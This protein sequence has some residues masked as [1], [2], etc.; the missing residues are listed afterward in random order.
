MMIFHAGVESLCDASYKCGRYK[1]PPAAVLKGNYHI[2]EVGRPTHPEQPPMQERCR[3]A[4]KILP[5]EN[6]N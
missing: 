6:V 3:D 2:S 5:K 4:A 1:K